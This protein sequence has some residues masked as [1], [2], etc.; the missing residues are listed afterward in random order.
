MKMPKISAYIIAYNDEPNIAEAVKSVLWA[1]EVVLVDSYSTDKTAT[2]AAELG[3]RVVQIPFEGFGKLRTSA[4]ASTRYEWVFSL[5]TDE[6]CTEAARQEMLQIVAAADAADAYYVP[7]KNHFMGRWIR[8]CGWYPDYRQPQLFRRDALVF[9][10]D[11]VHETYTVNGRI[12]HLANFIHQEPYRDLSHMCRKL[13]RYSTL[14][15]EKVRLRGES[16]TM[17]KALAHGVAAFLRIYLVKRGFLDGWP[18]FV[19]AFGNF[20]HTFYKYAKRAEQ[21]RCE[22][23]S[24]KGL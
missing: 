14:G 8:H 17:W 22:K 20:E 7:R 9:S 16:S 12:G 15:A 21:V 13:E 3:A 4:I 24:P 2:I 6:R 18:G 5:D 11:M 19:I 23:V 10:E 1:D